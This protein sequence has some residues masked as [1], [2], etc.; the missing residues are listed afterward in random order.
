MK[1]MIH[2]YLNGT[3]PFEGVVT[4]DDNVQSSTFH[5]HANI[6][7]YEQETSKSMQKFAFLH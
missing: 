4:L 5:D 6:M 3:S 1:E 2:F 7:F